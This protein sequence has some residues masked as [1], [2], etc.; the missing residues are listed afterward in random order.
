MFHQGGS[1][2]HKKYEKRLE[3]IE[4]NHHDIKQFLQRHPA[5]SGQ[6]RFRSKYLK[7]CSECNALPEYTLLKRCSRSKK[8][9]R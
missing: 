5:H 9:E 7:A 3:E 8:N 1:R 6:P 4:L 2:I